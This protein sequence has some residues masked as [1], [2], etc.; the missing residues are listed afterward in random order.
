MEREARAKKAG[1]AD[2][3]DGGGGAASTAEPAGQLGLSRQGAGAAAPPAQKK[4][5]GHGAP[6]A[7]PQAT[8]QKLPGAAAQG[9]QLALVDSEPAALQL[10][11][12]HI[13]GMV[14]D[15][16]LGAQ[17]KP[18]GQGAQAAPRTRLLLESVK[19]MEPPPGAHS[20][21][22]GVLS[23]APAPV[24]ESEKLATPDVEPATSVVCP[25]S[26]DS[27]RSRLPLISAT[28][29]AAPL[30]CRPTPVGLW[31]AAAVPA[32]GPKVPEPEASDPLPA[33]VE[34]RPVVVAIRLTR[35]LLRSATN[36]V[37]PLG[38]T[39]TV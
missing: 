10:P 23:S 35:A 20:A 5:A 19:M 29:S 26:V 15:S 6:P 21:E 30:G 8:P 25:V 39:A 16:A 27:R 3:R 28:T 9:A 38:V 33:R 14:C 24:G 31:K 17:K 32:P 18:A 13:R 1:G 7:T 34:T 22:L 4:P 36:R 12:A 2:R 11:A 37:A